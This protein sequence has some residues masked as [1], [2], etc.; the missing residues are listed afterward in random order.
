MIKIATPIST[1]FEKS[2]RQGEIL[3]LSDAVELRDH[4]AAVSTNLP[5]LFH[6]EASIIEPWDEREAGRIARIILDNKVELV[7]FHLSS[8]F[9]KP[10]VKDGMF[11]PEGRKM[12]DGEMTENAKRN[13]AAL[14]EKVKSP[15]IIA[16]E[17][18]NYYP[19]EAYEV[20]TGAEFINS[21]AE[22]LDLK[23]LLD[24]SHVRVTAGNRRIEPED[25]LGRLDLGK[26]IQAHLSRPGQDGEL[27]RDAHDALEDEDWRLAADVMSRCP[28]LQYATVEY[29]KDEQKLI[30]M[31][32]MLREI[33][34]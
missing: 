24:I 18:N 3:A 28:N 4:S 22:R 15:L 25:Y 32:K 13:K 33:L 11:Q 31:L 14:L 8:C 1:L 2:P 34:K 23:I 21:L 30:G 12:P 6:C 9:V 27:W 20:V 5:R 16:V 26:V 7:S 17:N 19:T 29:Y 10:P